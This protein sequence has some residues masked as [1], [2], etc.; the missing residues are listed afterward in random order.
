MSGTLKCLALKIAYDGTHFHGFQRQ[1]GLR[2]VQGVLEAALALLVGSPCVV[3]GAGRT[4][5]GVHA[6]G[7]VVS[8]CC[9]DWQIPVDRVVPALNGV[10]PE[11][12]AVLAAA[13]VPPEFHPR[14]DAVLKVYRYTIL[15]R[16]V[17]CPLS[18]LY[19]LHVPERLDT[20]RLQ[21]AMDLLVGTHDFRA[22]QNTGRPVRSAV[23]TVAECYLREEGD[24]LHLYFA[25]DGFLYQMVRVMVGTLLEIAR[26]RLATAVISAA[27][28]GGERKLLG[29][30]APPHGLCLEEVRYRQDL[31]A[32]AEGSGSSDPLEVSRARKA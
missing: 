31:F 4:D 23:R 8:F 14:Y 21:A 9:G 6:R 25:A 10:L 15:R 13:E 7:Q 11:D 32:G 18:R 16:I 24:F 26:G 3:K 30:T 28:A 2:T 29:P 12:I 17:R 27:L 20:V 22:F 5:A 19:A 1:P